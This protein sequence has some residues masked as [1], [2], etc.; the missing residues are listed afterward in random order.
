MQAIDM[1]CYDAIRKSVKDK[2]R[3]AG[4]DADHHVDHENQR[5][6][7]LVQW[8]GSWS[9][10]I[11]FFTQASSGENDDEN[12]GWGSGDALKPKSIE[13][14]RIRRRKRDQDKER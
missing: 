3:D 4:H 9:R 10:L 2:R 8:H 11:D 1:S 13:T 12:G 7:N 5:S 14:E 6:R